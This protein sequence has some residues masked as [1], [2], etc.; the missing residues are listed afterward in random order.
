MNPTQQDFYLKRGDRLP[1]LARQLLWSDGTPIDLS[2]CA[3]AWKMVERHTGQVVSGAATIV[4]SSEG[5][6]EYSWG[7]NDTAVVGH[8]RGEWRITYPDSRTLT[9]P[10]LNFVDV[11]IVE[12]LA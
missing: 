6:V 5:R 11:H 3:V 9:V 4:S 2:G 7:V 10:T 1:A 12:S 8:F